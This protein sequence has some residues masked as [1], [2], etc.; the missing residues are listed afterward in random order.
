MADSVK[1]YKLSRLTPEMEIVSIC[2]EMKWSY[3]T[4]V[5]QPE[6]FLDLLKAK[7]SCDSN[8][9]RKSLRKR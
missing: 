1:W 5:S 3:Q 7:L 8:E 2:Q 9:L 6:W 4:Y